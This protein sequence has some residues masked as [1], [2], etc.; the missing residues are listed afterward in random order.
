MTTQAGRESTPL[1]LPPERHAH[2]IPAT[3]TVQPAP[4]KWYDRRDFVFVEFCV[5]DSKDVNVLFESS[6][7]IFSCVGGNDNRKR[8]NEIELFRSIDPHGSKHKRTD[9]SICCYLRKR[10]S[11]LPWPRLAKERAKLNWLSLDFSNWK[12]WE[13]DSDEDLPSFERFSEM[14]N[15]LA[16]EEDMDLPDVYETDDDMEESDDEDAPD[17]E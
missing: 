7:L 8:A 15:S 2:R 1:R 5:E 13:E 12:D 10:E 9:R 3:F 11:G 14:M 16:G 6:K 17:L 4:A